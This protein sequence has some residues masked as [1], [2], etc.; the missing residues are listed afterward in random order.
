MRKRTET[1]DRNAVIELLRETLQWSLKH[2]RTERSNQQG[3]VVPPEE[4]APVIN[5]LEDADER[6]LREGW[7]LFWALMDALDEAL[8][9]RDTRPETEWRPRPRQPADIPTH[10]ERYTSEYLIWRREWKS[11]T[12]CD[13]WHIY[14]GR[15][16]DGMKIRFEDGFIT[17][18]RELD[19]GEIDAELTR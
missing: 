10:D 11:E 14:P 18:T 3:L 7:R 5:W 2:N 1:Q 9:A 6:C 19:A 12:V 13:Y 17:N 4:I 8:A 16:P 15:K